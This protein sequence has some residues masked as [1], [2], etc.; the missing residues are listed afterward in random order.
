MFKSR[1]TCINLLMNQSLMYVI[2]VTRARVSGTLVYEST[3]SKVSNKN[4]SNKT[5]FTG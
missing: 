2:K 4:Y 5:F 1:Y 3:Q